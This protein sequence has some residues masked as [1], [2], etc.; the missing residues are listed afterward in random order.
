MQRKG[1][2]PLRDLVLHRALFFRLVRRDIQARYLGSAFGVFWSFASSLLLLLAYWFFL[3]VVLRARWGAAPSELYPVILFSGII[4]HQ[5]FA[6]V[7]GRA[8]SLIIAHS[9]YV[10]KVVFPI[11]LLPWVTV[12]TAI[13]HLSV[14][15]AIL[16]LGQLLIVHS[17][18]MTWL[19]MPIVLLP[20]IPVTAGFSWLVSSL[21]VYLRDMAHIVPLALTV[22]MFLSPI[23]YSMEMVPE[24]YRFYLLLNPITVVMEQVRRVAIL[25]RHPEIE[26]L[27]L[28]TS[29]SLG[30][31]YA[32]YWWF[33]RTKRG[34]ADVL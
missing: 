18:P 25:G 15:L 1:G 6:E 9:A 29:A 26:Q 17:V 12:A 4:V 2:G 24:R 31:M 28:Y 14:N 7:V 10:R 32:G 22:L 3:G 27:A 33:S 11:E 30:L 5:F 21:S 34:F 23:F 19:W 8:P 16:L 13:F 20:L